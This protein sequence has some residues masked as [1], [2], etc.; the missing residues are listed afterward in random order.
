MIPL[1]KFVKRALVPKRAQKIKVH[2]QARN[3]FWDRGLTETKERNGL[4]ILVSLLE[5]R[6]AILADKGIHL[7]VGKD[8]WDNE[9]NQIVSGI[10]SGKMVEALCRAIENIVKKLKEHF[11]HKKDDVNELADS[12]RLED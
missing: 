4:L 6:V 9:V 12:V 1:L 7:K 5:R 11:P 8:Y 10:L 2:Q 3:I